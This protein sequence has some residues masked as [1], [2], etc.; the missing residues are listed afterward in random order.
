MPY[1]TRVLLVDD[2]ID[3]N[4][5]NTRLLRKTGFTAHVEVMKDGMDALRYLREQAAD[6]DLDES[7]I[8][9]VIFLDIRM[10]KIDGF[11]FLK[12]FE[13]LPDSFRRKIV[14]VILTSSLLTIDRERAAGF[15][16]LVHYMIKPLT[17]Q[18][19]EEL[20]D[21]LSLAH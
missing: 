12:E 14:V 19:L 7:E 21:K 16:A 20:K 8:P 2:S 13:T 4:F 17:R 15:S 10:P 9:Q 1:T 5:I 11:E 3:D 18:K 6:P